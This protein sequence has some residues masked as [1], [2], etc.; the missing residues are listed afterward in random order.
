[1]ESGVC[2]ESAGIAIIVISRSQRF[3]AAGGESTSGRWSVSGFSDGRPFDHLPEVDVT[4]GCGLLIKDSTIQ[5][6]TN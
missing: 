6:F 1:M 2:G 4:L 3:G 5:Q